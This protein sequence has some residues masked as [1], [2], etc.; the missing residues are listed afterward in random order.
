MDN[1]GFHKTNEVTGLLRRKN[2]NFDFIPPYSPEL[3]PIE[4][5]FSK[6]KSCYYSLQSPL[7][8]DGIKQNIENVL[9]NWTEENVNF[10]NFYNHMRYFL[11]KAFMRE[12]F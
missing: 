9:L 12:S 7:N 2:D 6:L 11:D 3:N 5:V 4:G 8:F 10:E 1:V